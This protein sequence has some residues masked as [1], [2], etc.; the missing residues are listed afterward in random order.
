MDRTSFLAIAFSIALWI[1][2]LMDHLGVAQ[3][4]DP[5]F[6]A[7]G[8][9]KSTMEADGI[10][11]FTTC[12]Y[13]DVCVGFVF[14][15]L[16]FY[17]R[18]S[19]PE[20]STALLKESPALFIHGLVHLFQHIDGW[21]PAHMQQNDLPWFIQLSVIPFNAAYLYN[22]GVCSEVGDW[23]HL[24]FWSMAIHAFQHFLV[25]VIFALNWVNTWIILSVIICG[26]Y[27]QID[28]EKARKQEIIMKYTTFFV[29]VVPFFEAF[30]CDGFFS[31]I[32]GHAIFDTCLAGRAI[33]NVYFEHNL[34]NESRTTK[35]DS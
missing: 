18:K 20:T 32:G 16:A 7:N 34:T 4:L 13:E 22:S 30:A 6:R 25:P 3:I 1:P 17:V 21:P 35:K 15:F 5:I 24:L 10:N 29:L 12:F 19:N 23:K 31:R 11:T 33:L 8:F 9:C 28:P 27:K 26:Q 14:V 2:I